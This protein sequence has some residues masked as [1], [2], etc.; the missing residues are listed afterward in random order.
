MDVVFTKSNDLSRIHIGSNV[1]I[2]VQNT[3]EYPAVDKNYF[4]FV[5]NLH[6]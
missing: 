6:M 4:M 3:K 1:K 2:C 5:G